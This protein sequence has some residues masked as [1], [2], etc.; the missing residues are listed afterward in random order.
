MVY[1]HTENKKFSWSGLQW[2]SSYLALASFP[3]A[4]QSEVSTL[5]R[6]GYSSRW[7]GGK[8]EKGK[9][10][11]NSKRYHQI[12]NLCLISSTHMACFDLT[13]QRWSGLV[14]MVRVPVLP[15]WSRL[16]FIFPEPLEFVISEKNHGFWWNQ[17]WA[18]LI[19]M[20]LAKVLEKLWLLK[21]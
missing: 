11:N 13:V 1:P 21:K 16:L 5:G 10:T 6:S 4:R 2:S 8:E 14:H 7:R 12:N 20:Y 3:N 18:S 15:V 19:F 17:K 9:T